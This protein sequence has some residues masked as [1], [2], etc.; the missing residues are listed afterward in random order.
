[1]DINIDVVFLKKVTILYITPSLQTN[2][3]FTISSVKDMLL[4]ET[5]VQCGTF[6][7][8]RFNPANPSFPFIIRNNP[9]RYS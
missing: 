1:M 6:G 5:K 8:V 4:Q 7:R 9:F 3:I 2:R